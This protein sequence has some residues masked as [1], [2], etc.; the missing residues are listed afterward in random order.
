MG[1]RKPN[2]MT[3]GF[4]LVELLTV[5]AI[6]AILASLLLPAVENAM[7]QGKRIWC[8]NS[9]RQQGIA[10]HVFAHDHNGRVPMEVS[11]NEG[12]AK[13]FVQNGYLVGG[14]FYFSFRQFQAL[15]NELDSVKLLVCKNET[16]REPALSFVALQNTNLSYFI[17]VNAD[18]SKPGS[19][20]A[21]DRNLA[22]NPSPHP[23]I[24]RITSGASFWWT[25]ELHP[26]N[27]NVLFADGHVEQWNKYSLSN[28]KYNP[29][30][31]YDIF[32]PT[33]P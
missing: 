25:S 20:L 26:L 9:L 31:P 21:G 29:D 12:G 19:I 6:I 18:L 14:P 28:F 24:I 16:K 27:G 10:F 4:T 30:E 2:L 17:G 13:E 22:C 15:S 23:T 33:I 3:R 5:I 1:L 32:L 7:K 11:M 8:V